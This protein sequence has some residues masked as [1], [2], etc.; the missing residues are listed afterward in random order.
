[1]PRGWTLLELLVV[2]AVTALLAGLTLPR[3]ADWLDHIAVRRASGETAAFYATA[4]FAAVLQATPVR[5]E[6]GPGRLVAAFEGPHDSTFLERPGPADGR[7]SFS[8]SRPVIRIYP[9]GM[10]AGGSNTTLVFRRGRHEAR[11][12]ISRLGRLRR[13]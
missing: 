6:F 10:G 7:V 8:A 3:L 1:M 2:L 12:T 11:I 5:V 4:R 9:T 13:W